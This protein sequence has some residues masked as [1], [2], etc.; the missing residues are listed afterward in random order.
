MLPHVLADERAG[1]DHGRAQLVERRAVPAV[2]V[3]DMQA[4]LLSSTPESEELW[5]RV[6][7]AVRMLLTRMR[8][9]LQQGKAV[10]TLVDSRYNVR[11]SPL[12]ENGRY[13]VLAESFRTRDPLRD[14]SKRYPLTRREREV[15]RLLISG[16]T[17]AEIADCL[18]IAPSTVVLHLKSIMAKTGARSRSAV[19]GRIV[20]HDGDGSTH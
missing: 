15:V 6:A 7:P 9:G 20:Q 1:L 4:Q 17:T 2:F 13:V 8:E 3:V 16:A 10:R 14:V 19:V 18:S 5:D 11:I 12:C